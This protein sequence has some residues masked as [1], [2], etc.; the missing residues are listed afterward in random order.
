MQ[1][2]SVCATFQ[3]KINS[4]FVLICL[5]FVLF[6]QRT[7]SSLDKERDGSSSSE[8]NP[9]EDDRDEPMVINTMKNNS[10]QFIKHNFLKMNFQVTDR[11][12]SSR[13]PVFD[14]VKGMHSFF[15]K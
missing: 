5:F 14:H 9:P 12:K 7:N 11:M 1:F 6:L 15:V 4:G 2:Q 10:K 8:T 13:S 3:V